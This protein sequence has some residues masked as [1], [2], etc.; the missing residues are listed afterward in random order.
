MRN[1]IQKYNY[2]CYLKFNNS[3]NLINLKMSV[4]LSNKQGG[5]VTN[6]DV[7]NFSTAK[8]RFSF[9]KG[10]RFPSVKKSETD[11]NYNLPPAFG[12]RAPSFGFGDRF[13]EKFDRSGKKLH[14]F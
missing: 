10:P 13:T 6:F 2:S 9:G 4:T 11:N 14:L 7:T 8:Q 3:D 5:Y 12:R 1:E